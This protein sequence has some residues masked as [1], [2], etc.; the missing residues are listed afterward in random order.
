MGCTED[1]DQIKCAIHALVGMVSNR[2]FPLT[3][4]QQLF[5]AFVV[6][7]RTSTG[8]LTGKI[9]YVMDPIFTRMKTNTKRK[10]DPNRTVQVAFNHILDKAREGIFLLIH[11]QVHTCVQIV[12]NQ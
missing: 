6:R 9:K 3:K 10:E 5:R 1:Q 7:N 11:I 4:T 2:H 12:P 8:R